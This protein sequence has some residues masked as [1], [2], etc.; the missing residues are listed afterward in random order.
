MSNE[1]FV[2]FYELVDAAQVNR[3]SQIGCAFGFR[4]NEQTKTKERSANEPSKDLVTNETYILT[5][6]HYGG[7]K[8]RQL[9]QIIELDWTEYNPN[10]R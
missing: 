9:T 3:I 8:E 1:N 7:R 4:T 5:G 2:P 10:T 6:P